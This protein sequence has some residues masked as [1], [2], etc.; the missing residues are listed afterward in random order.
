MIGDFAILKLKEYTYISFFGIFGSKFFFL[1]NLGRFL[2]Y[3]SLTKFL[4]CLA[5]C[6]FFP[7]WQPPFFP[8]IVPTQN[9]QRKAQAL[10]SQ[11]VLLGVCVCVC[12]CFCASQSQVLGGVFFFWELIILDL[13]GLKL[14]RSKGLRGGG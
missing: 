8:A 1:T 10:Q 11:I 6:L 7:T 14:P 9:K 13:D 3:T 2:V 12:V 5:R 4:L